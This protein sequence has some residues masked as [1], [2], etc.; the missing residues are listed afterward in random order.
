MEFHKNSSSIPHVPIACTWCSFTRLELSIS[1]IQRCRMDW[2]AM[3]FVVWLHC[4]CSLQ[5]INAAQAEFVGVQ[6]EGWQ[7][8][9]CMGGSD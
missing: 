2:Y 6:T 3:T 4:I 9:N 5:I 8:D 1:Y 7:M